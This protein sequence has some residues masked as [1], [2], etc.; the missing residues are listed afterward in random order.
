MASKDIQKKSE[1]DL[2]KLV[3]EKREELRTLRFQAAGS[4][5]RD[6]TAMRN[7]KKDVA[8]ALTELTAR[9]RN[10]ASE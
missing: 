9:G 2:Q 5:M 8:R 1:K 10:E 6:V 7:T 4:G 3:G